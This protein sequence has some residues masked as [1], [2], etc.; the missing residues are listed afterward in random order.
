[1]N[2]KKENTMSIK[3]SLNNR[4]AKRLEISI[5]YNEAE[6]IIMKDVRLSSLT[7]SSMNEEE[8]YEY[9]KCK[10]K[11]I[12]IMSSK[13]VIEFIDEF[14]DKYLSVSDILQAVEN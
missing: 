1:M 5:M 13:T 12:G 10:E 9:E 3:E 14:G 6:K 4:I 8:R 11:A 2:N 7:P